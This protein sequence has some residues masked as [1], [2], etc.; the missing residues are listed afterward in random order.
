MA[1]VVQDPNEVVECPHC[2]DKVRRRDLRAVPT[3]TG[4]FEGAGA[5]SDQACVN[6]LGEAA[7]GSG[8]AAN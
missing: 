4:V 8:G 5:E 2:H 6:C 1:F 3:G 7:D